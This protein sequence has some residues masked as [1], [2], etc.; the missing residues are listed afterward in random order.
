MPDN[1]TSRIPAIPP[2]LVGLIVEHIPDNISLKACCLASAKFREPSQRRLLNTIELASGSGFLSPDIEKPRSVADASMRFAEAPYLLRYITKVTI[3]LPTSAAEWRE[4]KDAVHLI[5]RAAAAARLSFL[6]LDC[7]PMVRTS[8]IDEPDH[9]AGILDELLRALRPDHSLTLMI[10]G[11]RLSL[12]TFRKTFAAASNL[13]LSHTAVRHYD[14]ES[15]LETSMLLPIRTR[16][17]CAYAYSNILAVLGRPENRHLIGNAVFQDPCLL[18]VRFDPES[19]QNP[20]KILEKSELNPDK[21]GGR[22][23][24]V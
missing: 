3:H 7:D 17:F 22:S 5:L 1:E 15:R 8:N 20:R 18:G 9:A 19:G 14:E 12:S 2:E 23:R 10:K 11:L 21:F 6:R 4:D 16:T 13:I 24:K